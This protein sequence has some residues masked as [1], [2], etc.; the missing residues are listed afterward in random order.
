[1]ELVNM[2]KLGTMGFKPADIKQINAAGIETDQIVELAKSGYAV[3][4]VNEL[5]KL[6]QEPGQTPPEET[7]KAQPEKPTETPPEKSEQDDKIAKLEK[8]LEEANSTIKKI[9][10]DNASKDL[11]AGNTKSPRE[12]VQESLRQLY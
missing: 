1:M 6:A 9:Q 5:I 8:A 10:F 3:S 2:L 7:P 12:L 4:D 11:G